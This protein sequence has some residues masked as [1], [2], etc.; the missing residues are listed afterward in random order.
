MY[1][2][3]FLK[4]LGI[5]NLTAVVISAAFEITNFTWSCILQAAILALKRGSQEQ[6]CVKG[7][8]TAP[9]V[10]VKAEIEEP[11]HNPSINGGK[12]CTHDSDARPTNI[13][14]RH[15]PSASKLSPM[16]SNRNFESVK[17]ELMTSGSGAAHGDKSRL[18]DN[19]SKC[20]FSDIAYFERFY[21]VILLSVV[22]S[23]RIEEL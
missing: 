3:I 2:S 1:H 5:F 8:G 7:A 10:A 20:K 23:D 11:V 9:L 22:G 17:V 18:D 19:S 12:S 16:P 6:D 14:N 21:L 4:F 15:V 13:R